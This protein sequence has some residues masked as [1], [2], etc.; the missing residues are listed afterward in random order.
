MKVDKT[1]CLLLAILLPGAVLA[2]DAQK[3]FSP[4]AIEV[5]KQAPPPER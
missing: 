3:G 4:E 5:I 2:Q 1:A